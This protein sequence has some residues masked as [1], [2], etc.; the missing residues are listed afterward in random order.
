MKDSVIVKPESPESIAQSTIPVTIPYNR[1]DSKAKYLGY[2]CCG[3]T[4]AESLKLLD[5]SD[6]VLHSWRKNAEFK[7]LESRLPEL[8]KTLGLEYAQLEFLRNYRLFLHKDY[9]II[10][11][12]INYPDGMSDRDYQYLLKARAQ[13]TPQQL[14]IM[15][16]LSHAEADGGFDFT[17]IVLKLSK[18]KHTL[19]IQRKHSEMSKVQIGNEEAQ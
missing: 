16:V 11:K 14:S 5:M 17:D 9:S 4:S 18:E 3:F 7:G 2:R 12:S 13:Y 6:S 19:E 8:R 10:S 1:D 15:E